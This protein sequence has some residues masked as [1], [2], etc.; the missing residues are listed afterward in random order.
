MNYS[1]K[2]EKLNIE[3]IKKEKI[4]TLENFDTKKN[5]IGYLFISRIVFN[6]NFTKGYLYFNFICGDGCGWG[7]NIEIKKINGKWKRTE[8]FSGGIA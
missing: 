8:S 5:E 4:E 1:F 2:S 6:R 3:L 7:E